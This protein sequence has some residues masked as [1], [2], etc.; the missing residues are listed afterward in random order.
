MIDSTLHQ[1]QS[2]VIENTQN[3]NDEEE[4]Y[5]KLGIPTYPTEI[6]WTITLSRND[7]PW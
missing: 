2:E 4:L 1:D 5:Y 7:F 6:D 3:N